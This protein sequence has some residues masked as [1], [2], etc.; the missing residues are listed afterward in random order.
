MDHLNNPRQL[1]WQGEPGIRLVIAEAGKG[2]DTCG[3]EGC[4]GSSAAVLALSH[5][6]SKRNAHAHTVM[7]GLPSTA[8]PDGSFGVGADGAD[9]LAL[10]G[11]GLG[12]VA[13]AAITGVPDDLPPA[14]AQPRFGTLLA[15]VPGR[16]VV[17]VADLA[18]YEAMHNPDLK[19]VDSN[20]YAVLAQE[21]F[22]RVLV[23]DAAGN[24]VLSISAD[25]TI[26]PFAIFTPRPRPE[27]E[28][29]PTS[30]A[31][32]GDG[33]V[34]IGSLGSLQKDRGQVVKVSP[35]AG[36]WPSTRT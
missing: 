20:P 16:G 6:A 32:D 5:P 31:Q 12:N 21:Q 35:T 28:F 27:P 36:S 3:D 14:P 4:S 26:E 19:Q 1:N 29:V 22:G 2:G 25:G 13:L 15:Q 18:R 33:N 30:L 7:S 9:I 8:A 11:F 17:Q 24:D 34:Y 10:D 23:A